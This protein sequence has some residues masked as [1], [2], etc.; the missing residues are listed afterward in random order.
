MWK[1][2]NTADGNQWW[3]KCSAVLVGLSPSSTAVRISLRLRVRRAAGFAWRSSA[4]S[5]TG[6]ETFAGISRSSAAPRSSLL[7]RTPRTA[8][9]RALR[10][11][12]LS[13]EESIFNSFQSVTLVR[14]SPW[15]AH[16]RRT[17]RAGP[18]HDS[19]VSPVCKDQ[20]QT[21]HNDDYTR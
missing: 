8:G 4:P 5:A 11:V 18:S 16:S 14:S 12:C 10:C 3:R 1:Q 9:F 20:L 15:C 17:K 2:L 6:G 21:N 19:G 7:L 13:S